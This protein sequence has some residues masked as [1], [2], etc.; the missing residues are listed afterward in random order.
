M[1]RILQVKSGKNN[2]M[3][4]HL[5]LNQSDKA[6]V[7]DREFA[8]L[9]PT[10]LTTVDDLGP[11]ILYSP[12]VLL[13]SI[14][15]DEQVVATITPGFAGRIRQIW[16]QVV[17]AVTT[18]SKDATVGAYIDQDVGINEVQSLVATGATA[19]TFTLGFNGQ[20]TTALQWNDSAA[21]VQAALRA[22]NNIGAPDVVCTG[23]PLPTTPVVITFG[24][25]LA[26]TDV[27]TLVASQTLTTAQP[28]VTVTTP[29]SAGASGAVSV[30]VLGGAVAL[31]SA[32]ATPIGKI[33][34]GGR[35]LPNGRLGPATFGKTS[36]LTFR[37]TDI[38]VA[39]F[40][41]GSVIFAVEVGPAIKEGPVSY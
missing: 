3:F 36:V 26:S 1:S 30:P 31:T 39:A 13:N 15:E 25:A 18:A 17:V 9:T 21:N 14:T 33:V 4:G 16:A 6:V 32:N 10:F 20:T 5:L 7:T 11:G 34:P 23:G 2:I 29:G 35:V 41:E 19:G 27:P 12:I 28:V 37:T 38:P 40:S 22:L 24:G 8:R